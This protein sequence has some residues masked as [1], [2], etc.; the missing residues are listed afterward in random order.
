LVQAIFDAHQQNPK[1]LPHL[2]Q[3]L[4]RLVEARAEGEDAPLRSLAVRVAEHL[5]SLAAIP[6]EAVAP[7]DDRRPEDLMVLRGLA[8]V[9]QAL[10]GR[11]D[12]VAELCRLRLVQRAPD[13][14]QEHY[15][16]GLLYEARGRFE[17]GMVA[18]RC[19]AAL[20]G[21]V[22]DAVTWNAALCAT[23]AGQGDVARQ[24]W[25][26]MGFDVEMGRFGLPEGPFADVKVRLVAH[27]P[28]ECA[29]SPAA[30]PA[31]AGEEAW[32][33]RLSPCHGVVKS[34]L[35]HDL[36]VDYGDV[37]LFGDEPAHIREAG[38][39]RVPV[40][41]H[42]ATLL[43]AGCGIY[44]FAGTQRRDGQ[45][46]TLSRELPDD[47]VV[48]VHPTLCGPRCEACQRALATGDDVSVVRGKI[49]APGHL[50]A[51]SLL[52]AVDAA[53]AKREGQVRVFVPGLCR[54]A[55]DP[56]RAEVERR[57]M[58]MLEGR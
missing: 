40:Y 1:V 22:E 11:W 16:L 33:E 56:H 39:A 38:G 53:I 26:G 7:T 10:G 25:C 55:G 51:R 37:V 36:G 49:C 17:E 27:P 28:A 21:D 35:R 9:S 13:H 45:V 30:I 58:N 8:R 6:L 42:L 12:E 20:G 52:A 47:T 5:L 48:H 14:W 44:A 3:T 41:A 4:A 15:G 54:E 31:G 46:A 50:D 18:F 57:R 43:H 24:I 32:V 2:G 29:S 19:A 23:G 34:A